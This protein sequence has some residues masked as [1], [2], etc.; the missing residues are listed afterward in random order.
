MK[1]LLEKVLVRDR[2]YDSS[3]CAAKPTA[4]GEHS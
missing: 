2:R 4:G 3:F 1:E